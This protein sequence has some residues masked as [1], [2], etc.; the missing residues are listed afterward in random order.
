MLLFS[1]QYTEKIN[2][3]FK[4]HTDKFNSHWNHINTHA[5]AFR[6]PWESLYKRTILIFISVDPELERDKSG[7]VV[8][9]K[10]HPENLNYIL[11]SQGHTCRKTC[12]C[13]RFKSS[14]GVSTC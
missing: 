5:Q 11:F 1:T 6:L 9:G 3:N 13:F 10:P 14:N 4:I 7:T 2:T 12:V 8:C